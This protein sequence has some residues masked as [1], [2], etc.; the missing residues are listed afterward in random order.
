VTSGRQ[1]L[2]DR[3]HRLMEAEGMRR[4]D[5]EWDI[6]ELHRRVGGSRAWLYPLVRGETDFGIDD[7]SR[8]IDKA[9]GVSVDFALVGL[10]ESRLPRDVDDLRTDL[11]KAIENA[12]TTGTFEAFRFGL[13]ALFDKAAKDRALFEKARESPRPLHRVK[14]EAGGDPNAGS[15]TKRKRRQGIG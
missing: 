11:I 4:P 3:L 6:A 15:V 1:F 10:K 8:I 13:I 2:I 7:Y 12:K 9:F 5:G 14:L